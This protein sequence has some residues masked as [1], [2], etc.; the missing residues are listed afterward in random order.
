MFFCCHDIW[1][2]RKKPFSWCAWWN[3]LVI[4]KT[5]VHTNHELIEFIVYDENEKRSFITLLEIIL[6]M[7][8]LNNL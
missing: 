1:L 4:L 8:A 3:W 6:M 7:P 5:Y 2:Y